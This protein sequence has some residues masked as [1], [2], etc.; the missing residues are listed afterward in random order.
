MGADRQTANATDAGLVSGRSGAGAVVDRLPT[1]R[2]VGRGLF[3]IVAF[4]GLW[5]AVSFTQPPYILPAPDAVAAAF[6]NELR[7]GTMLVALRDSMLHWIPGTIVGTL[8]GIGLGVAMGW[9][10][11]V[12]DAMAP[13]VRLLR[14]VPPLALIGFA[15]AWFGINHTGAAFIVAVGALWINFYATYGAVENVSTELVDVARS[16]GVQHNLKLLRSVVIPAALPA[17]LTGVR[18]GIGR[19]WMLVVAAEIFGV[20]GIGRQIIRAGDNLRVDRVIAYILV[21]SIVYLIVDA[22]FRSVSQRVIAWQN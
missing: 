8:V 10:E 18:T 11:L 12:D 14:P 17:I 6:L 15:I 2:R 13:I 19:C 16:L 4:V 5:W 9:S 7:G 22:A 21:L 20:S 1:G 3:G